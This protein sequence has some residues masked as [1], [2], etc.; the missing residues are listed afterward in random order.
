M[1]DKTFDLGIM[2]GRF[3]TFHK[4]HEYMIEKALKTCNRV[5]I[6]IGSSQE[7]GTQQNPYTY[8]MRKKI[9]QKIFQNE[10]QIFPLP[11]IGV[12]NNSTWGDYVLNNVTERFGK[13]PD[14]LI[15]GK[16]ERRVNWFDSVD[17]VSVAELYIPK[18][19]KIS[20]TEMRKYMIDNNFEQWKKYINSVLWD[21]FDKLRE[22]VLKSMNNK[23]T[24]SI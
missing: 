9:L 10:I 18:V 8:E 16:E 1:N 14:I 3:Q 21:D 24:A 20:A 6:F 17:G 23:K 11:D 19:I 22:I 12:G 4:G 15:S 5:G 7:S 13:T 2:V